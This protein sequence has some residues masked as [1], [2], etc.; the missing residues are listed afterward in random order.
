MI[1]PS[2]LRRFFSLPVRPSIPVSYIL[3]VGAGIF[4]SGIAIYAITPI[5]WPYILVGG[6][7]FLSASLYARCRPLRSRPQGSM[8]KDMTLSRN[9]TFGEDDSPPPDEAPGASKPK[10]KREIYELTGI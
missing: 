4:I 2:R 5:G 6:C 3:G 1:F 7:I 9:R 10:E 8:K